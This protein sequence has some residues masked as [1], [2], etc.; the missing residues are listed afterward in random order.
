M[1]SFDDAA[2]KQLEKPQAEA[3]SD[4]TVPTCPVE[5]DLP[6]DDQP[7]PKIRSISKL[8]APKRRKKR[9]KRKSNW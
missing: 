9:G 8:T 6:A 5:Q 4:R 3:S 1:N 2:I 7:P